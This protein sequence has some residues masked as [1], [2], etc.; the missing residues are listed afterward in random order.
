MRF[1]DIEGHEAE[2]RLLV[3]LADTGKL[4]HAILLG[5]VA[6]IGKLSLARAFAQYIHCENRVGGD[7]CGKCASCRQHEAFSCA[8][9]HFI[10]PVVKNAKTK[11]Q[12]ST[13]YIEEWKQLLKEYD[14]P[15]IEAW[16]ELMDAGNSQPAIYVAE[17]NEII[18]KA[19]L[20][21]L[22]SD[23]K[24]FLMWLPEKLTEEA[25]NK[26]LKMIE[27]PFG[28]TVFILVS[29]EPQLIL[30]TIFSR[31]QRINLSPLSRERIK[32]WLERKGYATEIAEEASRL[33]HGRPA[34]A[35]IIASEDAENKQFALI[36]QSLM[37]YAYSYNITEL[38]KLSEDLS[39]LGREKIRR[40]LSYAS[41]QVRENFI[42]NLSNPDLL[43]LRA[44][45]AVFSAKFAPFIHA[46]N[47]EELAKEFS[48]AS[49]DIS[50]NANIKIT[51][52]DMS[53]KIMISIRKQKP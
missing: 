33:S 53:L 18:R 6:G 4:P 31:V 11:R 47:V 22:S 16:L 30:P 14:F 19:S 27:E 36:F 51:L 46:N 48:A 44:Q 20:S 37:R 23:K 45:E 49:S 24:I 12:V 8:D 39:V 15:S 2:K 38:K 52:F 43:S 28:D 1:A 41:A 17:S 26:L 34:K 5:G 3:Q 32:I 7:S 42:Y 40:L 21:P 29:D 25:A 13:D 10:Y 35:L 9:M 50:G